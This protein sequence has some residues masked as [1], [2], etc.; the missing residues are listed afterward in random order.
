MGREVVAGGRQVTPQVCMHAQEA[1]ACL[2]ESPAAAVQV[3]K[4]YRPAIAPSPK[5]QASPAR[6]FQPSRLC[7]TWTWLVMDAVRPAL[8]ISLKGGCGWEGRNGKV[9]PK[10]VDARACRVLLF[11]TAT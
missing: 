10:V 3:P 5:S 2:P 11:P 9:L 7:S 6:T 1:E 4:A 8:Q